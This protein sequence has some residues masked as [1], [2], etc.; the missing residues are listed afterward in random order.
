MAIINL[1]NIEYDLGHY[2]AA[3]EYHRRAYTV[4]RESVGPEHPLVAASLGNLGLVMHRLGRDQD[5]RRMLEEAIELKRRLAGDDHPDIAFAM[6]NLG[7]VYRDL[8][9]HDDALAQHEAAAAIW[10][11]NDPEHPYAA[12]PVANRGLDLLELGR[13]DEALAALNAAMTICDRTQVDPI[14]GATTRFGLARALL[15]TGGREAVAIDHARAAERTYA[16]VGGRY[17]QERKRVLAWL[18]AHE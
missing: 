5:A 13:A 12:Y 1:G 14:I 3:A 17:E 8:G 16:S 7:E 6:N 15:A 10:E 2:D 9:R 11:R 4:V 18:A